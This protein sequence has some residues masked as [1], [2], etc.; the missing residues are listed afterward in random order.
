MRHR[1]RKKRDVEAEK[2]GVLVRVVLGENFGVVAGVEF[3]Q[4]FGV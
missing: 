3:L 1:R 2:A 4:H